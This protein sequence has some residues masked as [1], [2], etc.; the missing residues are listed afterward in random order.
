MIFTHKDQSN[1]D[2]N[3]ELYLE[4]LKKTILFEIWL[5]VER[6]FHNPDN[7]VF[8][9]TKEKRQKGL[10]WPSIAHSMIGRERMNNLHQC[11]DSV[12]KEGIPGDF[13]ETGVWR[14][15]SCIFMRGFLKAHQITDRTVWAADSFEGLPMA[16]PNYPADQHSLS[17]AFHTMN[18]LKVSLEE[19]LENFRKYDLLDN[20]VAFLK[21]WFKD[22][23]P[24]AP[25]QKIAIARLD[26]D[27]YASTWDALSN[28][29][30]KVSLGGYVIIDDYFLPF[31]QEAVHDFRNQFGI[32]DTLVDIDG[33]GS[34][35]RKT[36]ERST[37]SPNQQQQQQ[38]QPP[39][40]FPSGFYN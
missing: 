20:Q 7:I 11:M 32:T 2:S 15:G 10:D 38:Q 16:D 33:S 6:N 19:V 22:T 30:D 4:L 34:Y 31:C 13:I 18:F 12:I 39:T 29:Y 28:L 14:G 24:A 17:V 26:G 25:I 27:M 5:E 23:L 3:A 37:A 35:W 21:G 1:T 40:G 36:K 8:D 9:P